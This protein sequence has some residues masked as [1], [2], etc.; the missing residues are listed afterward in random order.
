MSQWNGSGDNN[1]QKRILE[2][3]ITGYFSYDIYVFSF[4]FSAQ[5]SVFIILSLSDYNINNCNVVHD[6]NY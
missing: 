6:D 3:P 5:P 4:I 1:W 2:M